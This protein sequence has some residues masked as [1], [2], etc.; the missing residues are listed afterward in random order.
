MP[1][2]H[3]I[4]PSPTSTDSTLSE[5]RPEVSIRPLAQEN[6]SDVLRI[7]ADTAYF[8]EPVEAFLEDRTLFLDFFY[9]Y[10]TSLESESSWV[11]ISEE[12]VVGFLVGCRESRSQVRKWLRYI[13]PMVLNNFLQGK[14]RMGPRT[15]R[16]LGELIKTPFV[17]GVQKVDLSHFPAH[18]HININANWRGKGI[19]RRLMQ[20]YLD[21]LS[22]E[23]IP[24]V[25]LNTTNL[26][27][28][29]CI[30]YE[31]MGFILL[32]SHPSH[33]WHRLTGRPV[34]D[35]CYG[36]SIV[37]SGSQNTR[38]YDRATSHSMSQ[39]Q[40]QSRLDYLTLQR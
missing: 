22:R 3:I 40:D 32:H 13:F 14:Y 33:L 6:V 8:G 26:N 9:W 28:A 21:Q 11:A 38:L 2:N 20:A 35:R 27:E 1:E 10:Y 37:N 23:Y 36:L 5:S 18:L 17:G 19:G 31:K 15:W 12:K 16:Y 30:L 24:G 25:Y 7:A 34:E 4:Q 29:A 39:L